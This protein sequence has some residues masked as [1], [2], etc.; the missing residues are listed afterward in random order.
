MSIY[1]SFGLDNFKILKILISTSLILALLVTFVFYNFSAKFK[2]LYLDL[3]NNYTLD[4][5]YLA[6]ITEN[7]LW[8]KDEID[9]SILIVNA[10][11]IDNYYLKFHQ[12]RELI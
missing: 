6:V 1:K 2:Y 10:S 11:S 12:L 3:K 8:L 4:N 7:G 9:N 5:K